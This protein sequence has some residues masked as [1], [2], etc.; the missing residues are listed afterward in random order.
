VPAIPA[1]VD[2]AGIVEQAEQQDHVK[3]GSGLGSQTAPI[4]KDAS[5]MGN[6]VEPSPRQCVL[7]ANDL[8]QIGN[9]KHG[10]P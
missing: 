2:A 4:L 8:E 5:P 1:F 9:G 7:S 6:A 10:N 3:V